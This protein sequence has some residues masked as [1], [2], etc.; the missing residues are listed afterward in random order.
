MSDSGHYGGAPARGISAVFRRGVGPALSK[1]SLSLALVSG[2]VALGCA[3]GPNLSADYG[4]TAREN[5]ELAVGEF[6]DKDW[7]ETIAYADFV[8][9]RFP[10]SRYAVEAE[11]LI[12]RAQFELR[13][14][15][16]AKDAFKQFQK[17]HPTHKH[18]RN[19]WTAYMVAV[20]AYMAGPEDFF[21][22]PPHYQRD[23]SMLQDALI[24]LDYFF[25]HYAGSE[26]EP[27]ARELQENVQ[28]KLLEHELYVAEFYLDLDRPEAAIGR[29]EGAHR[30]YPGVGFDAE[31]LF[32][33]GV[34][35]LRMEEI[36]LARSTFTELQTQHADHHH[37]KQAKLYL[38]HIFDNYGPADPN[39]VRPDRSRPVPV[40]PP[41]PKRLPGQKRRDKDA[42]KP[43]AEKQ[44]PASTPAQAP[45]A[46]EEK[47]A[48]QTP[49]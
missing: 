33:L 9:I 18:V 13:E 2:G 47:N 40:T 14:Y 3:N 19:G 16:S 4:Q 32:L 35:Y 28:R 31:V 39:R 21:L 25:D 36:E 11:L 44:K 17:L 30:R 41:Q 8:R 23:Q 34:T 6:E 22:M 49:A 37:G 15:V 48:A 42:E 29:L 45:K 24:E 38:R 27:L 5:Y 20:S 7:E 26:L 10:F 1:L 46:G 43:P 12:A